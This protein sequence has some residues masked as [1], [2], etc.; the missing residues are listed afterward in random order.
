MMREQVRAV[1]SGYGVFVLLLVTQL[2]LGYGVYS[3]AAGG[4]VTGIVTFILLSV[5][6]LILWFGFF[7][8]H[9]NEAKV[10]QLFGK[11]VGTAKESGLRWANPLYMKQ[12][13]SVRNPQLRERSAEGQRLRRQSHRDRC[14]GGVEGRGYGGGRVRGGRL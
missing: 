10:L 9:P 1:R 11:Y 13:V 7:M 2:A 14:G 6:V 3:A 12:A 4:S 8:V 5:L